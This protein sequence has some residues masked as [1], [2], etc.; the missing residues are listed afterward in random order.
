MVEHAS[1][2]RHVA[3]MRA[4]YGL[5]EN[6]RFLQFASLSFDA[7]LEQV[8]CTL[9]SG[10]CLILRDDAIWEPLELLEK[11]K[12]Y[13]VTI[14]NLPPAYWHQVAL[15]WAQQEALPDLPLR[16]VIIGGDVFHLETLR[17]W[18]Q[19]RFRDVRL[20]NAYGPTETTITSVMYEVPPDYLERHE[21]RPVPIG[22]ALPGRKAYILDA[23]SQLVPMG[24]LVSCILAGRA[25]HAVIC[26]SRS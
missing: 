10:A 12:Q 7:A 9:T 4:H 19:T 20:L 24:F 16:L 15:L 17:L 1:I 21:G 11:M 6:D 3:V 13:G 22:Q 5:S 8:F 18:G 14:L 25:W 23:Y 26:T 2:A